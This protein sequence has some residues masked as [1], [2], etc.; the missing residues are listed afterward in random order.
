MAAPSL[1]RFFAAWQVEAPFS[2]VSLSDGLYK[3]ALSL[4][5]RLPLQDAA[6]C[7]RKDPPHECCRPHDTLS[8]LFFT[9]LWLRQST[10]ILTQV[11][12][13]NDIDMACTTHFRPSPS[14]AYKWGPCPLSG[15]WL[16]LQDLIHPVLHL[17][18][19]IPMTNIQKTLFQFSHIDVGGAMLFNHLKYNE[20]VWMGTRVSIFLMAVFDVLVGMQEVL[21][22]L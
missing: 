14:H 16:Q 8:C 21:L 9:D 22:G 12:Q 6:P 1:H 18:M 7:S 5:R 2:A 11:Q 10:S 15:Q 17:S 3:F 13:T 20:V 4:A 19:K